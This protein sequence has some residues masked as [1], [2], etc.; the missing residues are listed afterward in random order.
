MAR[1]GGADLWRAAA[2]VVGVLALHLAFIASYVGGLHQPEPHRVP[3]A[4][5]STSPAALAQV[6]PVL[7]MQGDA[8]DARTVPDEATAR[9]LIA[10]RDVYAALV[11]GA[12]GGTGDRL[13]IATAAS[14]ALAE[15][16]SDQ[17]RVAEAQAS[18]AVEVVDVVPLPDGDPRGLSGFYLVVGWVVGGYLLATALGVARGM[19]PRSRRAALARLGVT[20]LY[21][22]ASGFA[23]AA[24]VGPVLDVLPRHGIPLAASGM[25]IVFAS[26][27]ATMAAQAMFGLLGTGLAI[28]AF[29]VLGNPSS[30][31]PF[32]KELLPHFW[33]VIGDYLP[34][35]AGT[36]LTRYVVYFPD[37][38]V[39]RPLVVLAAYA[40]AGILLT[41]L[42]SYRR[43]AV[44]RHSTSQRVR[45]RRRRQAAT[46]DV[47]DPGDPASD[48]PK[49]GDQ[50]ADEP[51]P[52]EAL[53]P[54]TATDAVSPASFPASAGRA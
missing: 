16:I 46:D 41:L 5:A 1:R 48:S 8:I 50:T 20:A 43:A 26:A 21:S 54:R 3:I 40:G 42:F 7:A 19:A 15:L 45:E 13:L 22:V 32:Q 33:R 38:S 12:N 18:R 17:V 2:L 30:G 24:L 11:I 37:A 4:I 29:V 47:G 10:H 23:G 9:R 44:G 31:G 34:P 27:A 49:G 6:Q 39:L 51:W 53:R 52:G 14:P 25:L 28:V 36:T 35:G